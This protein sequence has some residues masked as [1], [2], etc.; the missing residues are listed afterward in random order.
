MAAQHTEG[1]DAS[2]GGGGGGGASATKTSSD[3]HDDSPPQLT[4]NLLGET[5]GV[6]LLVGSELAGLRNDE[7]TALQ[8][9]LSRRGSEEQ[10]VGRASEW[11]AEALELLQ[12]ARDESAEADAQMQLGA[13]GMKYGVNVCARRSPIGRAMLAVPLRY[14]A[15][16]ELLR[17]AEGC[18]TLARWSKGAVLAWKFREDVSDAAVAQIAAQ[19]MNLCV[20]DLSGCVQITD[21]SIVAMAESCPW[22]Q[23]VDLSGKD[24]GNPSKITDVAIV[25]LAKKCARLKSVNLRLCTLITDV[26]I[27]AFAGSC[28][29]LKSVNLECCSLLTDAS[30]VPLAGSCPLLESVQLDGCELITDVSIAVLKDALPDV[31]VHGPELF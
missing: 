10:W 7:R 22:L 17:C 13:A 2:G 25:A 15:T 18:R 26:S 4:S 31:S 12:S 8:L 5:V 20:V 9:E 14:L 16:G 27:V 21:V 3:A 30:I 29:L 6:I 11:N 24:W 1:H 23:R 28:P 19:Y